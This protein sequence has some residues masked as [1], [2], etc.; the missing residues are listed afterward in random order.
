MRQRISEN[1]TAGDALVFLHGYRVSFEDAA[2]QAAQIGADLALGGAT[3]FFSWPSRGRLF[4]YTADEA[5]I[6]A[7]EVQITQFLVDFAERSEARSVHVIAH[8]MGNRG[9]LRAVQRIAANA[10]TQAAKQELRSHQASVVGELEQQRRTQRAAT[11]LLS[12]RS[13]L[14]LATAHE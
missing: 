5:S 1:A 9:L 4:G 13:F 6:E 14:S 2:I 3:A 11:R 7:S 10:A 12:F 8:S